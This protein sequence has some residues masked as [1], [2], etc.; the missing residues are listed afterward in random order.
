M[1]G[2]ELRHLR[3]FVTAAEELNISRASSRLRISQPAVS[4][5]I[6]DL[7]D[8]LGVELFVRES[9]GLRLTPAGEA[10]LPQARDI[11]RR[12]RE[13][14]DRLQA[15]RNPAPVKIV[16]GYIAPMLSVVVTPALRAFGETHPDVVVDLIE[17]SP[18]DQ[19]PA[20][21]DAKIDIALVGQPCPE[22]AKEFHVTELNRT[23]L[24]A[25]V[26][27]H[28]QYA[29]RKKVKLT[30]LEAE[31]FIGFCEQTFPGR[32]EAIRQAC[33]GAGFA[34]CIEQQAHNLAAAIALVSSGKGVTLMP[35]DADHLPHPHAVFLTLQ[36]SVP[37]EVSAL[38]RR[39]DDC[40]PELLAFVEACVAVRLTRAASRQLAA[41]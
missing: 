10:F 8:E 30:E 28:H 20:L 16:V 31:K 41:A 23:P 33:E 29:L 13:A 14:V 18:G 7:E 32:N 26:S 25:V 17:L 12:S 22:V 3:Y 39:K 6:H 35:D 5:Q 24:A 37:A 40:R 4:R 34:P 15:F 11:L 19:I 27:D 36:P 21:R 1:T 38:V 2:M 9:G